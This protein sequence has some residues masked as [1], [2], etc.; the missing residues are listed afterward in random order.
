MPLPMSSQVSKM[1]TNFS[2]HTYDVAIIGGGPIGLTSS[3]LLSLRGFSNVLFERHP[4]TSIHPKA[5]G[6]NQRTT[7][8]FRAIGIEEEVYKHAAPQDVAG[9]TGWYTSLGPEGREIASRDAWGGGQYEEEYKKHSPSRYCILPQIRLEPILKRKALELNPSGIRYRSEVIGLEQ[10]AKSVK[11]SVRRGGT[12][13]NIH[14]RFA[15]VS[16]GGR[17]FTDQLGVSWIGQKDI[18]DMVT[19]HFRSP[20]RALHPDPRNFITWFTNPE[21]G[22]S[23]KTGFLYQIGPW[24][25]ETGNEEWVFV[26]GRSFDDP[27]NFDQDAVVARL[28]DTIKI[29]NLPIEMLSFNHW[30]VNAVHAERYRV[31]RVFLVGDAAHK[32]P[33]W[34]AL[35]VNTGI[36]DANNL[37]WKLTL[38]LRDE[39][40]YDRLLDSYDSERRPVGKRVGEWSLQNLLN[41]GNVMDVALGMTPDKSI[42]ENKVAIAPFWDEQLPGHNRKRQAVQDALITLDREFKAPGVELGWFYPFTGTYSDGEATHDSK[43][44]SNG[45]LNYEFYRPSA[46]PGHHVPHIWLRTFASTR[47]TLDLVPLNKLLLLTNSPTW[48]GYRDERVHVEVIDSDDWYDINS[49]GDSSLDPDGL[50]ALIIRPDGIIAWQGMTGMMSDSMFSNLID[51]ILL[52]R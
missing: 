26:C 13:E 9:R 11:L 25:L 5:C 41:H 27:D 2:Q 31:G 12:V 7:E 40:K 28:R 44:L 8:I 10:T 38:A 29:P 24:P 36:Q 47:A 51:Q 43:L 20:L 17:S 22:G 32:I 37:V 15:F 42:E 4:G 6:I 34:G 39:H 33:P 45:D 48:G 1:E 21:K 46:K 14:S 30:T 18:F 50:D 52:A 16:D 3:I 19:A 23:T 49:R 35:G